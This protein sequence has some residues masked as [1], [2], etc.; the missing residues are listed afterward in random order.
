ML[1]LYFINV[2]TNSIDTWSSPVLVIRIMG[3]VSTA[4]DSMPNIM[5]F[6]SEGSR[7]I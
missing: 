3:Q 6:M 4:L 1:E 5:L 7:F 2:T